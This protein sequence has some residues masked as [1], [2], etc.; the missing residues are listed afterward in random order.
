MKSNIVLIG[1]PGCGKSTVGVVLAKNLGYR[2]LDVDL[3]IQEMEGRL[4]SEILDEEGFEGFIATEERACC[5]IETERTV[6]ATGG[7]AVYGE[8]VW[9]TW[10][11]S[12]RWYI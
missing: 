7:S 1:M 3:V 8:K 12:E 5:S 4:L 10:V 2:F 9:S 11:K 6:I